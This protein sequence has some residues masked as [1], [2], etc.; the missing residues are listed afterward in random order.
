MFVL[1][2]VSNIKTLLFVENVIESKNG[3]AQ[4]SEVVRIDLKRHTQ[5]AVL[6][7]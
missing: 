6:Y 1:F 7:G 3:C 5:R 2:K 4:N